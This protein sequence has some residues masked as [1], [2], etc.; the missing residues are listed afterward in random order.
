MK[1]PKT[2][3]QKEFPAE[4]NIVLETRTGDYKKIYYKG[5]L[6]GI[7]K[8]EEIIMEISSKKYHKK[9]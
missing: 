6:E 7:K 2:P 1:I 3:L 9:K 5:P 4:F 8:L